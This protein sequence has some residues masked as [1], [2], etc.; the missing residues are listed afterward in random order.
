MDVGRIACAIGLSP[1][2]SIIDQT[3][4]RILWS[5]HEWRDNHVIGTSELDRFF[6]HSLKHST[7]IGLFDII[8]AWKCVAANIFARKILKE[9]AYV[10]CR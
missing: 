5:R 3:V 7:E 1:Y 4:S 6:K 10:G 9:M 8:S 2:Q